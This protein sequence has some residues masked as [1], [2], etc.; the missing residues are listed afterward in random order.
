MRAAFKDAK[1]A[2]Y[3]AKITA[4]VSCK[5]LFRNFSTLLGKS[6]RV[7]LPSTFKIGELA[8]AFSDFFSDKIVKIRDSFCNSSSQNKF[9]SF[10]ATHSCPQLTTFKPVSE[11][12]VRTIV[13]STQ[14]K[15]CELDPMPTSL[16]LDNLDVILPTVTALI[17]E[18]LAT[19][20]VPSA[21]KIAIVKPL[22]KK[23]TLDQNELKNYRPVSNLPFWSKILEKVVLHQLNEHLEANNLMNK[24]QSAYRSNHSTETALLRIVND[25]LLSLDENNISALLLCDLSSAFDTIDHHLLLSCLENS[26]GVTNSALSWFH[27]YLSDRSQFISVQSLHSRATQ[28]EFGVPQGSVLG[29]ALFVLY[30][31]QLSTIISHHSVSH[32]MFADDT[33]LHNSSSPE[34]VQYLITSLQDCFSDVRDWMLEH[35]L[36]L[37]EEKTEAVL[38][39]S[40]S[41]S[42]RHNLPSSIQLGSASIPFSHTV[43]DLG[44]YLDADLSMKQHIKKTCQTA[45]FEIRRISSI[46]HFLT[47]EATK[48]LVTSCILSRIDYCN[49]LLVGC[50]SSVIQPLQ[51]VQNAAARLI[52]RSQKRQ[53]VTPLLHALHWLPVEQR[54]TYKTCCLCFKA[55]SGTAPQYLT[56]LLHVYTPSRTLRSSA[57]TRL[58]KVQRFS[59]KQHGARSFACSAPQLWNSL[60]Y[61]LRHCSTLCTFKQQLKTFLFRQHFTD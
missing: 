40:A 24:H 44:F 4:S 41:S 2:F 14:P 15:T 17:N 9:S 51:T 21:W 7:Q 11:E 60:P 28:L 8:N 18:S 58:L 46:R 20:S 59:R 55:I 34:N 12:F 37:N 1:T 31:T 29:P 10:H 61:S 52:F 3:S 26:F 35:K 48:T 32:E 50:P 53:H 27:S 43:R 22:L 6:Q 25:L 19:G 45:Y 33:Q 5:E 38:F 42:S 47:E 57:D 36:K 39:A 56:E 54:I 49:S 23:T 30:T 16:M 13:Q